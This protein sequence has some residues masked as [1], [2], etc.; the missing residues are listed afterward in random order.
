[1][2]QEMAASTLA[3]GRVA[4]EGG[5]KTQRQIKGFFFVGWLV[6]LLLCLPERD[7]TTPRWLNAA[8][9]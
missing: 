3:W 8:C 4:L 6:L 1:M 7:S 9:S 5:R 2:G